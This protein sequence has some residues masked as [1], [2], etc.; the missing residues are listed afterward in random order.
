MCLSWHTPRVCL[1]EQDCLDNG[2][3]GV[4]DQ[5][6]TKIRVCE[7]DLK[8]VLYLFEEGGFVGQV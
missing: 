5:G 3:G 8:C 2:M 7:L 4:E 6:K 1:N